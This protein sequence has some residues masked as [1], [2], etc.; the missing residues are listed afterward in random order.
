MLSGKATAGAASG[1]GGEARGSCPP[2]GPILAPGAPCPQTLG[3]QMPGSL[4]PEGVGWGE[5]ADSFLMG[6]GGVGGVG[7]MWSVCWCQARAELGLWVAGT[8]ATRTA[9]K[10]C[11]GPSLWALETPS[12]LG[13][14]G[15][16]L[17]RGLD[18]LRGHA[19]TLRSGSLN[20]KA[21]LCFSLVGLQSSEAENVGEGGGGGSKEEKASPRPPPPLQKL[22]SLRVSHAAC[23]P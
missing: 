15:T 20:N 7:A 4:F 10:L 21:V 6:T 14:A 18:A 8:G 9:E 12:L 13:D 22:G 5:A 11:P 19:G 23:G 17:C 16:S 3:E 1:A 2:T